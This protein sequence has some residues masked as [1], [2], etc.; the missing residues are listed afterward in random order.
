MTVKKSHIFLTRNIYL[1]S[2]VSLLTDI[3]SEML[4]PIMPLY[5]KH[6]GYGVVAIGFIE[7]AADVVAGIS[8]GWFGYISDR[9]NKR[10][11]FVRLG[12]AIS[13]FSKPIMAITGSLGV[14]VTSRLL[15]RFGKGIRT[16]PRDAILAIESTRENRGKVFGF[17]RSMDTLGATL[18]PVVALIFLYYYPAQYT[19]LFLI[20]LIPGLL[21]VLLTFLV[22][23]RHIDADTKVIHTKRPSYSFKAFLKKASPEYKALLMGLV[24]FSLINSSDMFLLLRAK[25]LGLQDTFIIGAYILYNAIFTVAAF[26]LGYLSD[27]VGSKVIY[28]FGLIL[29]AIVYGVFAREMTT[30]VVFGMFGVYGIF[31]AINESISKSWLSK[32]LS[33]DSQGTGLGLYLTCQSVAFLVSSTA[34]GIV[35]NQWGP[36]VVFS[37]ISMLTALLLVY[38]VFMPTLQHKEL[39]SAD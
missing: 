21:A 27:K 23:D 2:A 30:L 29:F 12:Y 36:T 16:A 18:G 15:D 26:P 8:K 33:A 22:K 4:Y 7:G 9:L 11:L 28:I 1:L 17:H 25:E 39:I 37:G 38:F 35:W 24:L 20:V 3:A 13:T 14:I 19:R 32:H 10:I 6:I 34:T 31:G 5:L